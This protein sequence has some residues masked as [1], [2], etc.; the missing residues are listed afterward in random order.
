M[1]LTR[2]AASS[3]SSLSASSIECQ[4]NFKSLPSRHVS[5]AAEQVFIPLWAFRHNGSRLKLS[6]SI[7]GYPSARSAKRQ[8]R[9]HWYMA[10]GSRVWALLFV[11]WQTQS[12]GACVAARDRIITAVITD[13][14]FVH[15]L[16]ASRE[17]LLERIL[18][19]ISERNH[20][21]LNLVGRSRKAESKSDDQKGMHWRMGEEDRV[22]RAVED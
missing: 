1:T 13:S 16:K 19:P 22:S 6:V 2:V 7:L 5:L 12:N 21:A 3:P 18:E 11:F 8:L 14:D 15:N 4:L 10:D 20:G 17:T 9:W